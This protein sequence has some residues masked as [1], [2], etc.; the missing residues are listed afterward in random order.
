MFRLVVLPGTLIRRIQS[1]PLPRLSAPKRLP[2]AVRPLG[3]KRV[4]DRSSRVLPH[5]KRLSAGTS[6]PVRRPP[7]KVPDINGLGQHDHR[8]SAACWSVSGWH[9]LV[10]ATPE[11]I[12]SF[13]RWLRPFETETLR[14]VVVR[15]KVKLSHN[16]RH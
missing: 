7:S 3:T 1:M 5:E 15:A 6:Q 11:F 12:V 16:K 4:R 13:E 10:P 9:D 8:V 2:K 14:P